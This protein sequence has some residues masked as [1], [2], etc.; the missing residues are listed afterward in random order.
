MQPANETPRRI[1]VST[2]VRVADAGGWT[3]TWFAGRGLVCSVAV[4]PAVSVVAEQRERHGPAVPVLHLSDFETSLVLD[5]EGQETLRSDHPVLGEIVRRHLPPETNIGSLSIRSAVPAGSSLG[6]SASVGVALIAAIRSAGGLSVGP[7]TLARLA[8]QAET[9]AGLQSGVQDHV[10]A[11]FG[12]ASL[13]SVSYPDFEVVPI[14]LQPRTK[15]WLREALRTVFL[16]RH[17]SSTTHR[18]V[19][20]QL[21]GVVDPASIPELVELRSAAQAAANALRTDNRR[22]YGDALLRTVE[23]QRGLHPDLIGGGAQQVIELAVSS[24][25]AAKVNGAGGRGGSITLLAPQD[26]EASLRFDGYLAELMATMP[27]ARLLDL[28]PA[29]DGVRI[30]SE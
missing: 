21:E 6:T 20:H 7:A 27:G 3:D 12:G 2:P 23:A 17:D 22:A 15:C 28:Q 5:V 30:Q 1:S 13:I 10:G 16:G 26:P 29:E 14:D 4:G 25:G 11:A 8:H 9:D 18:M 19:I 24:G